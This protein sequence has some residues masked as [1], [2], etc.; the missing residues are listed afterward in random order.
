[1]SKVASENFPYFLMRKM[2]AK[3]DSNSFGK[4]SENL[5]KLSVAFGKLKTTGAKSKVTELIQK[6]SALLSRKPG[7]KVDYRLGKFRDFLRAN[8]VD[9]ETFDLA[10]FTVSKLMPLVNA[11]IEAVPTDQAQILAKKS[12]TRLLK[13]NGDHALEQIINDW[14]DFTLI[15]CLSVENNL[16][17]SLIENISGAVLK[18]SSP[19]ITKHEGFLRA[20]SL[21]EF[22]RRAGQKRKSRSGDDLH[23]A[24]VTILQH[25][26]IAHDPNPQLITGVIEADLTLKAKNGWKVLVSCKRTGRERVK[27]ATT[28]LN[29]LNANRIHKMVWFFT[30]FDQT[31]NRVQDMG[32]RG[33]VF[34]LPDSSKEYK[35]LSKNPAISKYVFPISSIRLTL[36]KIIN[37]KI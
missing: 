5:E 3:D 25:L 17:K 2:I 7:S 12:A 20:A 26:G 19:N 34:Y 13:A 30:H 28:T 36:N 15:E 18:A 33:N 4:S 27:Q 37:R 24:T 6:N 35:D 10:V 16:A 1:M 23:H 32:I 22:E 9:D 11:A 29:E 21:Q 14:D 31:A 8:I